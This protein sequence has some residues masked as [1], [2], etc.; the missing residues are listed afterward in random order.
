[1]AYLSQNHCLETLEF[2]MDANRYR[3]HFNNLTAQGAGHMVPDTESC[4]YVRML[5]SRLL[6]A[7]I[8]PNGPREVNLPGAVRETLL[9][10]PNHRTPPP[11]ETLDH[12]VKIV[13]ELMEM[14]V[15]LPFLNSVSGCQPYGNNLGSHSSDEV[16][17]MNERSVRRQNASPPPAI[18][19]A[20][21]SY[22]PNS[23]SSRSRA[24]SPYNQS[25]G[26]QRSS[27][28]Y[29]HSVNGTSANASGDSL[30]TDDSSCDGI[31]PMT[32]PSTPPT[33]E[34]P[35]DGSP[36]YENSWKKMTGK[37]SWSKKK[38]AYPLPEDRSL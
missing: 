17:H 36:R 8:A 23:T 1:M 29:P 20:S 21:N 16:N 25:G 26:I 38:A 22:T 4:K 3:K 31:S 33:S 2:T 24:V 12:A 37:L 15:L 7:Y 28:Q 13:Y 27:Q 5:W 35:I 32:P 6:E 9:N 11:P 10:F 19:I 34:S 14:S 30:Y 18:P